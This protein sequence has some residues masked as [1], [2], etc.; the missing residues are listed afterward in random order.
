VRSDL[1]DTDNL[2][3][4][5]NKEQMSTMRDLL[6]DANLDNVKLIG[7]KIRLSEIMDINSVEGSAKVQINVRA[8]WPVKNEL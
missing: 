6:L 2:I 7:A 4:Y 3:L 8:T 1:Y 5:D